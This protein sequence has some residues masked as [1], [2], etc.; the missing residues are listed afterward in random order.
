MS[1][2]TFSLSHKSDEKIKSLVVVDSSR[3]SLN[4]VTLKSFGVL[5]VI[6][7]D[8]QIKAGNGL[9]H[10]KSLSPETKCLHVEFGLRI[11]PNFC[12][13]PVHREQTGAAQLWIL[14]EN[15]SEN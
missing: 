14:F 13:A 1:S 3:W 12:L 7:E 15:D 4:L 6:A 5:E 8:I 10:S 2:G 11:Q 9:F